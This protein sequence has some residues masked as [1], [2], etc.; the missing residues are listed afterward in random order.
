MVL[1][2][3]DLE[4]QV[5]PESKNSHYGSNHTSTWSILQPLVFSQ[6][7]DSSIA[8][9]TSLSPVRN[10][11]ESFLCRVLDSYWN[12]FLVSHLLFDQFYHSELPVS[13]RVFVSVFDTLAPQLHAHRYQKDFPIPQL[14]GYSQ[15][16]LILSD[17]NIILLHWATWSSDR[18]PCP[19]Q[20]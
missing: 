12:V 16:S 3:F 9:R 17:I 5:R 4:K 14:R 7:S 2:R 20:D 11:F 15:N 8:F 6:Y 19:Q 10:S 13:S 18:R 1:T